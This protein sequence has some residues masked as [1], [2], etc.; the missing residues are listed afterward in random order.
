M[1]TEADQDM[2]NEHLYISIFSLN[3]I[4]IRE[5]DFYIWTL[6]CTSQTRPGWFSYLSSR[7]QTKH[8]TGYLSPQVQ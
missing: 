8:P 4:S 3:N 6:F 1:T 2:Y 7:M 5:T